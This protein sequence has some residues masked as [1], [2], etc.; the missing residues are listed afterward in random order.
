MLINGIGA[1]STIY[2]L[3]KY[4][5]RDFIQAKTLLADDVVEIKGMRSYYIFFLLSGVIVD[6]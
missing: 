2:I 4:R 1:L 3:N 5:K 6:V